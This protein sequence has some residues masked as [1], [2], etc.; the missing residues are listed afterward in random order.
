MRFDN[1]VAVVTGA[2]SGLGRASALAFAAE[3]ARFNATGIVNGYG[4]PPWVWR[5]RTEVR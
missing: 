2:G 4:S 5:T 1:K 3:G